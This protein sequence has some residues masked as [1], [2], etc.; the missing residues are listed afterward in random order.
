MILLSTPFPVPE[1]ST[2]R[3]DMMVPALQAAPLGATDIP[4]APLPHKSEKRP[5]TLLPA[6]AP[7]PL[8]E[9]SPGLRVKHNAFG[10]G[11][12]LKLTPMGGDQLVELE[13]DKVGKKKLMLKA[14]ARY[15]KIQ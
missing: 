11:T 10:E 1:G 3:R 8:P 12:V 9:L 15:L 7:E 5:G 14:A 6:K 13:F 2:R 4:P